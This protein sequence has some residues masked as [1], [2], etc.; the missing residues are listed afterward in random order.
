MASPQLENGYTQVANEILEALV[1]I[2]LS[3]YE[4][5][6]LWFIIRKTYGWHKTTDW[7]SLSQITTG[8]A[9]AK[10]NVCRTIKWLSS[11]NIITR[12]DSRH[13]G[14]QKDYTKWSDRKLS[15]ETIKVI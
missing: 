10:P 6:V 15:V 9:I 8:T 2:N 4:S 12:P 13:V 3:P 14:F 7:I 11:R 1:K 5:R